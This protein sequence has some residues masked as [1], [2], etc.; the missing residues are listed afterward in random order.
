M[1]FHVAWAR[2]L[3][4]NQ[5]LKGAALVLSLLSAI[6]SLS[7][8]RAS[9]KKPVIIERGCFS[10]H[11]TPVDDKHSSKEIEEFLNEALRMRFDSSA[12]DYEAL[13][14]K[15]ETKYREKE[16]EDLKKK[17]FSQRVLINQIRTEQNLYDIELDK[18]IS[19][20]KVRTAVPL[21]VQI[22][23]S[24]TERTPSNPYGLLLVRVKERV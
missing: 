4:E 21:K 5:I 10:R 14:S 23:I 17:G 20:G 13:L 22:E 19:S 11:V 6:L 12:I 24:S 16:Q 2:V 3:T 7:L 18:V 9:I 1:K 8:A 15:K